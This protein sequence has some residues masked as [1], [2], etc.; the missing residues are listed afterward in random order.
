MAKY[1]DQMNL[2]K[3]R[4]GQWSVRWKRLD[5]HGNRFAQDNLYC[6]L[7]EKYGMRFFGSNFDSTYA[8][9]QKILIS[10][11]QAVA[12]A[13]PVAVKLLTSPITLPWSKGLK[14]RSEAKTE[15]WIVN[16]NH[17]LK[18]KSREEVPLG[19]V[20]ARLAWV[21]KFQAAGGGRA[22][23][24]IYLWIDTETKEV[25]GGDFAED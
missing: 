24:Y 9:G 25:L 22:D 6:T 2:P 8:E 14:L 19:D 1:E 7:D 13:R 4:N 23:A 11:E 16:P 18:Y 21:A 17:I 15:L 12:I 20:V 10:E 3:Y 5:A